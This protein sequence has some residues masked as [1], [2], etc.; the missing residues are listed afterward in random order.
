VEKL[1]FTQ[2][3]EDAAVVA[4]DF[5]RTFLEEELP[6]PML[7]R[8]RLNSSYDG[9]PLHADEVTFP[10]DDSF[11]LAL[12]LTGC[13][14]QEAID[15]LW[16]DGRVPEWVD[17]S[18]I[19]V[20][21]SATLLQLLCCGRFTAN[22]DLLYHENE[23]RPP[24]HVTGPVLPARF[25]IG[26]THERF[27][28]YDRTECWTRED[29]ELLKPHAAKVWSL[30]LLGSEF[31]DRTLLE[32]P[33][34][35]KLEILELHQSSISG[36]GLAKIASHPRLRVLRIHL[37]DGTSLEI[38]ELPTLPRLEVLT[39]HNPPVRPWSAA[40][41]LQCSPN[42]SWLTLDAD[43]D[44]FVDAACPAS[45]AQLSVRA[46]RILG[47]F[48][49]PSRLE[50]AYVHLSRASDEDIVHFFEDVR[51]VSGIDLS[52][53]PIS[54]AV[55]ER[56]LARYELRYLNI[57]NTQ[58]SKADVLRIRDARPEMKLLPKV[59]WATV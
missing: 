17:V 12:R 50:T 21:R 39:V 30:S 9:N 10:Q 7:F 57:V 18:V 27:S 44:L 33:K 38:P 41:L 54:V 1:L 22:D 31:D 16:R 36:K 42:L 11:R 49:A 23:G 26:G 29:I 48:K 47:G 45:V 55:I 40:A 56:L 5:A 8:V 51:A 35:P 52:G 43:A 25:S 2:R 58:A 14:A 3:L 34:L 37:V 24:F 46:H 19:G 15:L 6:D 53:T 20:T 59:G 13:T 32:L 4:R 28:I